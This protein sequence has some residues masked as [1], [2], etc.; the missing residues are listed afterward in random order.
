MSAHRQPTTCRCLWCPRTFTTDTEAST[1]MHLMHRA[2]IRRSPED[3]ARAKMAHYDA[4]RQAVER[5]G[6]VADESLDTPRGAGKALAERLSGIPE[7]AFL[8]ELDTIMED[9]RE[10]MLAA[11][12]APSAALLMCREIRQAARLERSRRAT[13]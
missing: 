11:G 12:R 5:G 4:D 10:T 6:V 7:R 3:E 8:V 13:V 9:I 2:N 1:H